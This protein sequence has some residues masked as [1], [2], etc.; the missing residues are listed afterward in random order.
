MFKL[1]T[2]IASLLKCTIAITLTIKDRTIKYTV[3]T[4]KLWVTLVIFPPKTGSV[5]L[6]ATLGERVR[7]YETE[8]GTDELK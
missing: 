7:L 4:A 2:R 1:N 8:V 3:L 5:K 6:L